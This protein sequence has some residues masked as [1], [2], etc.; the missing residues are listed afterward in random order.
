[1]S[2]FLQ[3]T[4]YQS[5]EE[6]NE[7]T[8][9]EEENQI[10][11]KGTDLNQNHINTTNF[12][13]EKKIESDESE[14]EEEGEYEEHDEGIRWKQKVVTDKGQQVCLTFRWFTEK[15]RKKCQLY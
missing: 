7:E 4:I 1:M 10:D 15:S 12:K 6:Q 5:A 14:E 11:N 8:P 13:N 9:N 2:C 3:N